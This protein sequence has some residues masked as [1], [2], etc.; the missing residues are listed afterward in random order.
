[1]LRARCISALGKEPKERGVVEKFVARQAWSSEN[2]HSPPLLV[3][4]KCQVFFF[5]FVLCNAKRTPKRATI[6]SYK[7]W[8][9]SYAWTATFSALFSNREHDL[10]GCGFQLEKD[11]GLKVLCATLCYNFGA[12]AGSQRGGQLTQYGD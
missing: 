6:A 2:E 1:M 3:G 5:H 10:C 4:L 11:S 7:V 12:S 9:T 8:L